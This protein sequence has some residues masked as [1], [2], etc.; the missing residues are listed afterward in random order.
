MV[1]IHSVAAQ[2]LRLGEENKE[3]RKRRKKKKPQDENIMSASA[4]QGGH[5][6]S[7]AVAESPSNR[8][9]TI[10]Q[11]NVTNR[12]DRQRSDSIGRTVL[13]TVA[14]KQ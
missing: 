8:L 13:Q 9:A 4:T 6:K 11:R 7:S 10:Y 3:E 5:N 12:Q 14:P 1:D 2:P